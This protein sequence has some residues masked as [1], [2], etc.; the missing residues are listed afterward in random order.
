MYALVIRRLLRFVQER[1]NEDEEDEEDAGNG[2]DE[3]I[4]RGL[5]DVAL[6]EKIRTV[7]YGHVGIPYGAR[8]RRGRR[9]FCTGIISRNDAL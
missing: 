1:Q 3:I 5:L 4:R 8:S 7:I 2:N 6:I 9:I